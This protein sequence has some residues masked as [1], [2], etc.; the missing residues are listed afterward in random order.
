MHHSHAAHDMVAVADDGG[1][2]A[3]GHNHHYPSAVVV[4]AAA[5]DSDAADPSAEA[6]DTCYVVGLVASYCD[7]AAGDCGNHGSDNGAAG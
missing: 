2:G 1:P 6:G 5:G 7:V 3:D 4:A